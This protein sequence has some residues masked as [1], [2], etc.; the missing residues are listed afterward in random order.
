MWADQKQQDLLTWSQ[1]YIK[2]DSDLKDANLRWS[3]LVPPHSTQD[4]FTDSN[5]KVH[6]DP[7]QSYKLLYGR[8]NGTHTVLAFSRN[9][10]TCDDN[11]KVITVGLTTTCI[12]T[13]GTISLKETAF[14][15][16]V[17]L[18]NFWSVHQN[19]SCALGCNYNVSKLPFVQG[20]TIVWCFIEEFNKLN[21]YLY[22]KSLALPVSVQLPIICHW[23]GQYSESDLGVPC[24][25]R[26]SVRTSLPW[27]EQ[28]QKES[29]IT[30]P[31][32]QFQHPSR[33][34]FLWP[35]KWGGEESACSRPLERLMS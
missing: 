30:Q 24:G 14:S 33:N 5:R 2:T 10:Q 23:P 20:K 21:Y 16:R 25:G 13:S 7:L 8:E 19:Q 29:A 28:R 15:G 32:K 22:K 9:L 35:S 1:Y 31:W 27:D 18:S 26:G 34:S 3:N 17:S 12:I 4:Y 6:K 11:D